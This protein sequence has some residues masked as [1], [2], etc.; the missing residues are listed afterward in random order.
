MGPRR[1][2]FLSSL[3]GLV[4]G[5]VA[6]S[7]LG[8]TA[9]PTAPATATDVVRIRLPLDLPAIGNLEAV[10]N[11]RFGRIENV[12][13]VGA[14]GDI[15]VRIRTEDGTVHDVAGPRVLGDLARESNW[16]S[17]ESS[18]PQ[19]TRADYVERMVAFDMDDQ[20]RIIAVI[21]LEP[22]ERNRRR[23]QRGL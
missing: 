14:Q 7:I 16:V 3:T 6:A 15:R 4:V 1:I 17:N 8:Q 21:S 23:L 2:A 18:R 12:V 19:I 22:M 13:Q 11:W 5:C 20:Q 9:P 10:K